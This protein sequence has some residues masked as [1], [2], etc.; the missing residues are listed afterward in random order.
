VPVLK[1]GRKYTG[2]EFLFEVI[3]LMCDTLG[4]GSPTVPQLSIHCLMCTQ[5][6][7]HTYIHTH[8]HTHTHTQCVCLSTLNAIVEGLSIGENYKQ[9]KTTISRV[10]I[11]S[12]LTWK[13]T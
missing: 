9:D 8:T 10:K 11:N 12:I 2:C 7:T 4:K 6:R 5:A 13:I 1:V 3:L